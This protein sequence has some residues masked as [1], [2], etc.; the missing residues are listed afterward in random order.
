LWNA[1]CKN[2]FNEEDV[3]EDEV[4]RSNPRFNWCPRLINITFLENVNQIVIDFLTVYTHIY[5][6]I[7]KSLP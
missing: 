4:V 2:Y 1:K 3:I 7:F 5:I 6:L